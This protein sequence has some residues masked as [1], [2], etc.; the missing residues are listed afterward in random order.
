MINETDLPSHGNRE[1]RVT[2]APVVE[3]VTVAELKTFSRIDGSAEDT[4]LETFLI[5]VRE[6]TESY[7]GRALITQTI[8]MDMDWW[9]GEVVQLPRPPLISVTKVEL[10]AEDGTKTEFDSDDYYVR[11]LAEP[12]QL[13]LKDGVTWPSNE[14]RYYGGY[15]VTFTAGYGAAASDVPGAIRTAI[16][17]WATS[18]YELRTMSAEPSPE[19]ASLLRLYKVPRI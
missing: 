3:P 16:M 6:A 7:L 9:P 14:D 15:L 2:T 1:W 10:V 18:T 12:G 4:L 13:V 5:S 8:E 17:L 11:T 19:V